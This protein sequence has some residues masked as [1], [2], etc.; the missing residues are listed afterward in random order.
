METSHLI[1]PVKQL[2]GFYMKRNSELKYVYPFVSNAPFLY[3]LKTLE[4]RW[5]VCEQ[6]CIGNEFVK[7]T[8]VWS[9]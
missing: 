8:H 5:V 6:W 4:N 3:L 2:T 9:S 7:V 1:C